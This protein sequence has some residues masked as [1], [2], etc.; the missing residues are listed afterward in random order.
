MALCFEH[1]ETDTV[2]RGRK[3]GSHAMT[4]QRDNDNKVISGAQ[5]DGCQSIRHLASL[6]GIFFLERSFRF[7]GKLKVQRFHCS[8][9][10]SLGCVCLLWEEQRQRRGEQVNNLETCLR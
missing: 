5:I 10:R 1:N 9:N 6:L 3:I 8:G 4:V 7:L 2:E